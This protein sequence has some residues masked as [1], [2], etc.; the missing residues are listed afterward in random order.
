VLTILVILFGLISALTAGTSELGE[1]VAV[2]LVLG[3]TEAGVFPAIVYFLS[4]WYRPEER[5]RRLG[6]FMWAN[7]IAVST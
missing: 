2:R 6:Y 3:V 5:G 1:L 4:C 7:V